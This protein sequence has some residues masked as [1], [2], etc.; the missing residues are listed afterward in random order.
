MSSRLRPGVSHAD[1]SPMGR[2]ETA[3]NISSSCNQPRD[4]TIISVAFDNAPFL[5][6]NAAFVEHFNHGALPRW[7]V[8]DNSAETA[9]RPQVPEWMEV[10]PGVAAADGRDRGSLHHALGLEEGLKRVRTRHVLLMDADFY[11]IRDRWLAAL[12]EH[13]RARGLAL[14]GSAWHPSW[15]YQYRYFPSV[16]F[17]WIDGQRVPFESVDL[18]PRIAG[19]RWWRIINDD[20]LPVPFR[21]T[22]K[23]TRIRDTGWALYRRFADDRGV[24]RECLVPHYVP[25]RG[26]RYRLESN[27]CAL[28]PESLCLYPKD[29]SFYTAET[30]L[31]ETL[32]QGHD[33][34]WEEF[35]W[36]GQPFGFH[37]RR[38]GRRMRGQP[39]DDDLALVSAAFER[40][41]Q[42]DSS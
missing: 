11:V 24:A 29:E 5:A 17:M 22:L 10:V 25:D 42:G 35:F 39:T 1:R 41:R 7:L 3:S 31:K 9:S 23:A 34:G 32:P 20:R 12:S 18:K 6:R 16:H 33:A 2:S 36:R 27:L 26:R 30:F 38:V 28:L 40:H 14:F 37:L 4:V 8:V 15:S 21:E 13:V 19:D